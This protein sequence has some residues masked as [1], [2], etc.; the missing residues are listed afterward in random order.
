MSRA[1]EPW[2]VYD[3]LAEALAEEVDLVR[4]IRVAVVYG[5]S[6][7][8]DRLYMKAK[9]QDEW[10]VH[11]VMAGLVEVG[12]DVEWLDPT[13]ADF[14]ERV[15]E[16]DAAFLNAHGSYGEDGTLQGFLAYLGVPYTGSGVLTSAIG[17]DKRLTKQL[18]EAARVATPPYERLRGASPRKI[19]TPLMLKA[20]DG[21]SSV[22]IELVTETEDVAEAA[23]RL[24]ADGFDDLIA[25]EFVP[26]ASV[27]VAVLRVGSES[28][29]LPPIV[30]STVQ[31][32]YDEQSKLL[33]AGCSAT[34][35]RALLDA[36]DRVAAIFRDV[37][38]LLEILDVDG[39]VRF[40]FVLSDRGIP[41]L[42][43]LNTL[44][45]LQL[46]SNLVLAAEAA[47]I[48]YPTLVGT[49]LAS[50]TRQRKLVPWRPRG[51]V[52][53]ARSGSSAAVRS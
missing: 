16:Y 1:A 48:D 43:E 26:G 28:A 41:M 6:S 53:A 37:S 32:Y 47:Y 40:D 29:L 33:G 35:Y 44:P 20:V 27:T 24:R 52:V 8:E 34:H 22:G 39:A 42:L 30:C 5:P 18:A 10:S 17:A 12:V 15:V 31:P 25:E 7:P 19:S 36:D 50:A 45:G 14:A 21:G 13:G 3:G 9:P 49:V 23:A 51:A 11:D 4:G 2:Y 46:G 38:A